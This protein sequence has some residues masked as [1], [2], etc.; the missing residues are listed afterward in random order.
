[1]W[2]KLKANVWA[3]ITLGLALFG[4]GA[5]AL[6]RRRQAKLEAAN[7]QLEVLAATEKI[8]ELR[9]ERETLAKRGFVYEHEIAAIDEAL[10]Q[11]KKAILQ[12]HIEHGLTSEEI[13]AEFQRLGY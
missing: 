12:V 10:E 3:W 4:L 13:A 5:V 7:N 11:N 1:M 9:V 8:T 2:E 6:A